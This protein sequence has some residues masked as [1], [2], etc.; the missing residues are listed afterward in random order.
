MNDLIKTTETV[1]SKQINPNPGL[2][3]SRRIN[4]S[5]LK[6]FFDAYIWCSLRLVKFKTEEQTE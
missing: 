4:F 1:C 3:I 6:L 2:K 5:C